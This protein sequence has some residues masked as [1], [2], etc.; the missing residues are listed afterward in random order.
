MK[1]ISY[2]CIISFALVTFVAACGSGRQHYGVDETV[3]FEG[4]YTVSS[5]SASESYDENGQPVDNENYCEGLLPSSF[6]MAVGNYSNNYTMYPIN[7][8]SAYDLAITA[9][10]GSFDGIE[11]LRGFISYHSN[12][13]LF[14]ECDAAVSIFACETEGDG[15]PEVTSS[16]WFVE[17][18]TQ[19]SG[20]NTFYCSMYYECDDVSMHH[21]SCFSY[22]DE[23]AGCRMTFSKT[24]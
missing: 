15:Y 18:C 23:D 21:M 2:F 9:G 13:D 3:S 4:T 7:E 22:E 20:K 11:R 14:T 16:G 17:N 1:K 19:T 24:K 12:P 8:G 10:D 6:E 5:I